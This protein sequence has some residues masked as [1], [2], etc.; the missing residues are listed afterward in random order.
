MPSDDVTQLPANVVPEHFKEIDP[1]ALLSPVRST[2]KPRILI[3]YGSVR[4]RSFSRLASE[5]AARILQALDRKS[6]V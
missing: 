6:V 3:L 4:K 2:H 5:E 1:K